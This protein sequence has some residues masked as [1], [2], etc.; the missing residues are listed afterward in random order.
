MAQEKQNT[1]KKKHQNQRGKFENKTE[2][3]NVLT[4]EQ[5][6]PASWRVHF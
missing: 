1:L 2:K 3:K 6:Y 5:T 4:L